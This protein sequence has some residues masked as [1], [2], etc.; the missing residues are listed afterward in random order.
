MAAFLLG[1]WPVAARA[2]SPPLLGHESVSAVEGADAVFWNPAAIGTRYSQELLLAFSDE[3]GL[4]RGAFAGRGLGLGVAIARHGGTAT[5]LGLGG[6]DRAARMGLA[7]TRWTG[8]GEDA[9]DATF[10]FLTRPAPWAS[11]GGTAAHLAQP[12]LDATLL[13]RTYTLGIG[14]RPLALDPRQAYGWGSRLTA[15]ADLEARENDRPARMRVRFGGELE[16]LPGLVAR[17]GYEN[18]AGYQL[19]VALLG[20]R[21]GYHGHSAYDP[22]GHRLTTTHA[23]SFH[24]DEDR[25]VLPAPRRVGELR[26]GG[27]LG[28]DALL[29]VSVFGGPSTTPADVAHRALARALEDPL[30]RGVLLD[31]RGISNMAQIEELRRRVLKLRS[32]GK[33]VVA[34]LEYGGGRGDLYL[35]SACDRIVT[36]EEAEFGALGL[37]VER[38]NYRSALA[39][40]GLRIDR[41]SVGAYKSAFRNFSVDSTP[42]A[43]R[44][45]LEHTLDQLQDMFVETIVSDRHMERSRLLTLLDGRQWP[46]AELQR[47]GLVDSLGERRDALRILGTLAGLGPKPRAQRLTRLE[48]AERP[49]RLPRPIALVY[50]SG[51]IE[52]GRSGSDL[53][54]GPYVGSE[55]LIP[56]LERAF[57]DREVKAV[58]LRIESPGGS[59]LASDR[60]Y[61]ALQRIKRESKK[62]LVVSMG[63][64]AASGGYQ[65]A[66]PGDRVFA[67]RFTRT[68]SI[69]VLF[70]KPS[71]EGFYAKRG[72]HQEDFERGSYM[73]GWSWARDWDARAQAAADSAVRTTYA[74]FKAKVGAAR[75][76]GADEV[77]KVAQGRVWLGEEARSRR[78]VDEMGGLEEAMAEARR[79]AHVPAGERID[80]LVLRRPAPDL[81]SRLIGTALR[82]AWERSLAPREVTGP[83]LRADLDDE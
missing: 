36:T 35:A 61:H 65:I 57:K 15:T 72:V 54:N 9:T 60:M 14:L 38:R 41:A 26:M 7:L 42:P 46:A 17:G 34:Y 4:S 22:D 43:D 49:W 40:L 8:S 78:L 80:P 3:A 18:G 45:V 83:Q 2:D 75:K 73:S 79:L 31:L 70:V 19:G 33:P 47:A 13:R 10:G 59:S 50:A 55:T 56:Q 24:P 68:G 44:E 76:L 5:T 21:L 37:R 32:A 48:A 39:E 53:L 1:A 69:G 67:D 6:G 81:L 66:L 30:T 63:G 11:L 58:V 51:G 74:G 27:A 71:L 64:V 28:D 77:E 16:I 82:E 23:L 29:G 25:T 20:P 52:I 12:V 62:P